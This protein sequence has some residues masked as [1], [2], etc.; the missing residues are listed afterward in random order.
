MFWMQHVEMNLKYF[1]KSN[2][3]SKD[4]RKTDSLRWQQEEIGLDIDKNLLTKGH[5]HR[6]EP[7]KFS[8]T[9]AWTYITISNSSSIR[10]NVYGSKRGVHFRQPQ[11]VPIN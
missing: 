2:Y 6:S 7:R 11:H 9:L 1:Q 4:P 8:D 3:Q 10:G 5:K